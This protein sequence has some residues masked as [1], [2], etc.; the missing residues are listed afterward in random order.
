MYICYNSEFSEQ[1]KLNIDK[2]VF[3]N[4]LDVRKFFKKVCFDRKLIVIS[5]AWGIMI[6]FSGMESVEAM[7][8]T[9]MPKASIM[10]IDN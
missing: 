9:H 3:K 7:G 5:N 6:L 1:D 8:L 2:S 10:I 4:S